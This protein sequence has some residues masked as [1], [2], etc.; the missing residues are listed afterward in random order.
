M[1][2]FSEREKKKLL[3]G[4]EKQEK[5]HTFLMGINGNPGFCERIEKKL[6]RYCDEL[7]K[8]KTHFWWLVGILIG[9]G[10]LSGIGVGIGGLLG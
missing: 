5:I 6:N 7:D 2:N 3:E 4:A 9:L 1:T 10:V 8:L